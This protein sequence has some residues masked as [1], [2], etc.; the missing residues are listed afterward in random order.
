MKDVRRRRFLRNA[1]A[2]GALGVAGC[3]GG[4]GDGTGS[5]DGTGNGDGGG[6]RSS[7]G[8][9][10]GADETAR[11]IVM[12]T[13]L[14]LT[15]QLDA[16]GG[17]MQSA[18]DL[19]VAEINDAGGP[20]G[21]EIEVTHKDSD[22][23]ATRSVQRYN[24]LVNEEGAI[25]FV[26]AAG[27]GQSVPLAE[28]VAEDGVMQVSPASTTP[29]LADAGVSDD[30]TKYFARTAPNDAQQGIV[31]GRILG[32]GDYLDADTAAFLYINNPYGEG[33]AQK[34]EEA[35]D[36]ETVASVG[37]ATETTDYSSTLDQVFADDPDAVG[38]VGYPE[39]GTAIFQQWSDGG[40][41]GN[42]VL[43][44]GLQSQDKFIEPLG[45]VVEGMYMTVPESAGAEGA[46]EFESMM[47]DAGYDPSI[48]FTP[49]SYDATVLMA[50]AMQ[51]AGEASGAAIARN[52]RD[53]SRPP[54]EE[55]TASEVG[56]ALELLSEGE[57]VNYQ[58]ASSAIDFN[59]NLE[60][61]TPF[62]ISQIDG[63][64]VVSRETVPREEFEGML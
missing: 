27:S 43:S 40:Y 45:E 33:L 5:G 9:G 53:V 56:D 28:N 31:M 12:G 23:D 39:N 10:D 60:P 46:D 59:E 30:G 1:G 13:I 51:A 49:H 25:C 24:E 2:V 14:P 32:S 54:G 42:W 35:F 63:G 58:G 29:I 38:F 50:L 11:S 15:G 16:Y 61:V 62:S 19:A 8:E 22:T 37:Y 18:V 44:E 26:G 47:R 17:G 64:E 41:G 36:G 21:R 4:G 48:A 20:L 6:N 7:S 34:A 3:V 52:I 57:D 55:V